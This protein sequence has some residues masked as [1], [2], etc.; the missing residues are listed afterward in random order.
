M[1]GRL[2]FI[3]FWTVCNATEDREKVMAALRMLS[4]AKA[5]VT[6]STVNTHFGQ[7]MSVVG[8]RFSG[9][10][11]LGD[12]ARR[13]G[14]GPVAEIL[15]TLEQRLDDDNVLHFRL[16]KQSCVEGQ[17]VLSSSLTPEARKE[18]DSIDVKVHVET[19]PS[20]RANAVSFLS[21]LLDSGAGDKQG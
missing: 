14:K 18:H 1:N 10:N 12:L 19:Y 15:A 4:E 16:D 17:P 21:S 7:P 8:C 20:S 11:A 2:S 6:L 5:E 9:K 3:E 13:M